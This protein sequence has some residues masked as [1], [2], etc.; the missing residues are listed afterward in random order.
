MRLQ[1]GVRLG[2]CAAVL[3]GLFIHSVQAQVPAA[4]AG[5]DS[6]TADYGYLSL[7]IPTKTAAGTTYELRYD[8][9]NRRAGKM[10]FAWDDVGFGTDLADPVR[11]GF[12]ATYELS[13]QAGYRLKP[14]TTLRFSSGS[15]SPPAYLACET[16]R[17]CKTDLV[18]VAQATVATLLAYIVNRDGRG[19]QQPTANNVSPLR[20]VVRPT[21]PSLG[22][23]RIEV[24]WTAVKG[25]EFLVLFPDAKFDMDELK[26]MVKTTSGGSLQ[27]DT[28]PSLEK[29]TGLI[30]PNAS[31]A[32]RIAPGGSAE[33]GNWT[34]ELAPK[35]PIGRTVTVIV[36]D[37]SGARVARLNAFIP[38]ASVGVAAR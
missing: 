12:C 31:A 30:S 19:L 20:V 32:I 1:Q 10:A 22:I 14:N 24:D 9:C 8:V 5:P 6:P 27:F 2:V 7:A 34:V 25:V 37:P 13:S 16:E 17:D 36:Q 35:S 21:T 23:N 38:S 18:S 11:A 3:A 28:F 29:V 4:L 33:Y 26:L 15:Q